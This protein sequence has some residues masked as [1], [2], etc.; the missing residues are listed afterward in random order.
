MAVLNQA[1]ATVGTR[2]ALESLVPVPD[3]AASLEL[4]V[5]AKQYQTVRRCTEQICEPLA[6]EDYVVQSMPD[7][8]PVKWHLAHTS[9]FFENF[10]LAP[11]L[12]GYEPFHP[13]FGVLFNSYYNAVGP[14][15]P[16]SQRGLLS[17]PTVAEVYAYRAHVD[18]AMARLLELGRN[19]P[20]DIL[21]TL[22]LGLNHEQQHQEL[23]LTDVKHVL[24]HNSPRPVYRAALP[25]EG[26]SPAAE[27]LTFPAG[28]AMIGHQGDAFA[29]DNEAPRHC[30]YLEQFR[31]ANRL[32]TCGEYLAF[33]HD[34]GYERPEWWLSDGWSTRQAQGWTCPLYWER[35]GKE[36]LIMTLAGL[37]PL[38]PAE[39]VCHVSFYEADGYARWAGARLPTEAEW[40]TAAGSVSIAGHFLESGHFHPAAGVAVDDRGPL[41]QLDGVV[42]QWTASPY[43]GY[44]G[45][46]PPVGALGEYNGKFMCNQFV[47]RGASC[48]T[49]RSHAR[50]S[51]RNFFPPDA[52]WQFTGIRLAQDAR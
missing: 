3:E 24:A 21:P 4:T 2:M 35:Q 20:A 30:L 52:R 32:V 26:T 47:L 46:T 22:M 9:W 44:P 43:V 18:R 23:I 13:L 42:W 36:W 29:F 33:V 48:V 49:P 19:L 12:P 39:P 17:R 28:L 15:W 41:F 51:Y 1:N 7:A 16:R 27:W 50:R 34:G 10:L 14:R 25:S 38:D 40:E 5:F 45:Y 11:H 31:L 8:S 37:R 6:T